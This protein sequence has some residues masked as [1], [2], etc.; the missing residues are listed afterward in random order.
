LHAAASWYTAAITLD[1]MG[2]TVH[3][4]LMSHI[5]DVRLVHGHRAIVPV[6]LAKANCHEVHVLVHMI[7]IAMYNVFC[8]QS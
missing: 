8:S 6:V 2:S 1:G 3:L 4:F 7:Q 5:P